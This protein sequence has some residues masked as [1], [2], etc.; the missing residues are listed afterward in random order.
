MHQDNDI[1]LYKNEKCHHG[2]KEN[3]PGKGEEVIK[4]DWTLFM[5]N[6]L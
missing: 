2:I 6:S 1:S 3:F 4:I 5:E